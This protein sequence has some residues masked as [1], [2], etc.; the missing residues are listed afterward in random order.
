MGI[1][2]DLY[3]IAEQQRTLLDR[4]AELV[5]EARNNGMTWRE[6]ASILDM[7]EQGLMKAR[8]TRNEREKR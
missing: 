2:E 5:E 3:E 4:R 1:R 6:I 8:R 7:T